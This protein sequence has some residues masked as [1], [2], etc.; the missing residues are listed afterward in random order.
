MLN[1][2]K[3]N[4]TIS[5]VSCWNTSPHFSCAFRD[6]FHYI[7]QQSIREK[8]KERQRKKRKKNNGVDDT[9]SNPTQT[10]LFNECSAIS[11]GDNDTE[12]R[13][14][15]T[16]QFGMPNPGSAVETVREVKSVL[17]F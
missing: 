9:S 7:K 13:E 14:A 4:N 15:I 3:I 8:K 10:E 12:D 6:S 2:I 11:Y 16:E 1:D 17:V 5:T